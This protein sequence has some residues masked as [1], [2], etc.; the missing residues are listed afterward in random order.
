[1]KR[2]LISKLVREN[3]KR[4]LISKVVTATHMRTNFIYLFI[5]AFL[6]PNL[7]SQ[8]RGQ[9]RAVAASLYHSHSST[10]SKPSV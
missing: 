8:A 3:V 7:C 2:N 4:N 1:M 10:G 6:G 9:L 5:F